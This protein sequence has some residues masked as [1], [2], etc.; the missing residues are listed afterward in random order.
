LNFF[1]N[2]P[3]IIYELTNFISLLKQDPLESYFWIKKKIFLL[4]SNIK[5][6]ILG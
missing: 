6:G 1:G 3:N 2:S 5:K 4:H